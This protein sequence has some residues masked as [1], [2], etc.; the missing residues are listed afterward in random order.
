MDCFILYS[1]IPPFAR[2]YSVYYFISFFYYANWILLINKKTYLHY[3]T[4]IA[5]IEQ[6][7][8]VWLLSNQS[9]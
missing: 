2:V 7:W 6:L 8:V 1:A 9:E 5:R 3:I 4:L